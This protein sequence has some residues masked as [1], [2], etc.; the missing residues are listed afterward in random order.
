ML[1]TVGCYDVPVQGYLA[2]KNPPPP[3]GP[4]SRSMLT[5]LQRYQGEEGA[6]GTYE[7]GSPVAEQV[8]NSVQG[9]LEIRDTYRP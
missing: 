8:S 7:R 6:G 2:H 9:L 4:Y 3:L 5:V 1:P